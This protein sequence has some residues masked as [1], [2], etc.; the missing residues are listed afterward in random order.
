MKTLANTAPGST[1]HS[2]KLLKEWLETNNAQSILLLATT[3]ASVVL[4]C[5]AIRFAQ[6][7]RRQG[8]TIRSLNSKLHG[9]HVRG[10]YVSEALAPLLEHFPVPVGKPGT[11]T[12]FVG[13]PVDYLYFDEE[14]GV[15]FI[16]IKSGKA[17]L[18]A[19]QRRLRSLVEQGQ[20]RWV[21]M[22]VQGT[23]HH[24]V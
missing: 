2:L 1:T 13:Q 19:R 17:T 12:L 24:D 22:N 9:Q 5:L 7:I 14:Q 18:S 15:T 6:Q 16:E 21:T 3:I 10:G 23:T 4:L 20:V 8:Q 11:T